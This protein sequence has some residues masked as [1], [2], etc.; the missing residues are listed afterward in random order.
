MVNRYSKSFG[1]AY[2]APFSTK[3]HT[4]LSLPSKINTTKYRCRGRLKLNYL[5]LRI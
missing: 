4:A 3:R 1:N 5:C 2:T